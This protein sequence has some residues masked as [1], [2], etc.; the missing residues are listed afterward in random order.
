[1]VKIQD[2]MG[3]VTGT[4]LVSIEDRN[5]TDLTDLLDPSQQS[6]IITLRER[7]EDETSLVLPSRTGHYSADAE[8]SFKDLAQQTKSVRKLQRRLDS[9]LYYDSIGGAAKVGY[10]ALKRVARLMRINVKTIQDRFTEEEEQV[11]EVCGLL[12]DLRATCSQHYGS[13]SDFREAYNAKLSQLV[14]A[15]PG[16]VRQAQ[17]SQDDYLMI[18]NMMS[19]VSRADPDYYLLRE[20]MSRARDKMQHGNH[21]ISLTD[22]NFQHIDNIALR[23]DTISQL[24]MRGREFS[25]HLAAKYAIVGE[26]IRE[27]APS[28]NFIRDFLNNAPMIYELVKITNVAVEQAT[29]IERQ[30]ENARLLSKAYQHLPMLPPNQKMGGVLD[31]LNTSLKTGGLNHLL[32]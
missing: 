30:M 14:K 27:I 9:D 31:Y 4:A 26:C 7:L 21:Q 1:M 2:D 20:R 6:K 13:I 10:H 3:G 17:T 15:R 11:N 22:A 28:A 25:E 19:S 12:M 5:N 24:L 23:V 32:R 8:F 18:V 29:G 16:L